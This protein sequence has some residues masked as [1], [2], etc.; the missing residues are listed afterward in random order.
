[1]SLHTLERKQ[2]LPIDLKT[3]WD[4]FSSPLNLREITPPY[5]N[6]VVTSDSAQE[7]MYAGMIITY[8]VSPILSIPIH[9]VTEIT[10]VNEPY[11]F[12]DEQRFGPYSLWHHQ[13][14]FK[15]VEGG[16]EM[17]DRVNY[18]LPFGFLGDIAHFLFVKKQLNDIFNYRFEKLSH[19]FA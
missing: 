2:F 18:K 9:W 17:I 14:F 15:E 12:V 6:F 11:F 5:M 10:H 16:V 8:R 13:H 3:A 4:F 19:I 1:M 7:K